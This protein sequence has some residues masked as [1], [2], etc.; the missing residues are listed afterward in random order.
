MDDSFLHNKEVKAHIRWVLSLPHDHEFS[1][2]TYIP[3]DQFHHYLW[4]KAYEELDAIVS[5]H[6]YDMHTRYLQ[7]HQSMFPDIWEQV[8]LN[9]FRDDSWKYTGLFINEHNIEDEEWLL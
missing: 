8:S 6:I 2:Y 9:C 1:P 3:K 7:S 5:D 4:S